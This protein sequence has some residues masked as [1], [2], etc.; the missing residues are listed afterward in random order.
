MR[1]NRRTPSATGA[2]ARLLAAVAF[3]VGVV[4]VSRPALAQTNPAGA[5]NAAGMTVL[6]SPP[7]A[8][9]HVRGSTDLIGTAPLDLGP[10]WSGRY[11]VV[12][13]APGYAAAQGVLVFPERGGTPYAISEPRRF[14]AKLLVHSLYPPGAA[15]LMSHRSARGWAFVAAGVGGLG[16]VI[17]DQ[18]EY[19]DKRDKPDVDLQARAGDFR[20]AR[21][22]WALYTGAVWALSAIDNIAHPR[23]DVLES[24]PNRVTIGTPKITRPGLVVRSVLVPGAGQDYAGRSMRGALW[25]GG[26][27]LSGAAYLTADE[28]HH[29]I[30]TKLARAEALLLTATSTEAADRQA[31]VDHFTDLEKRSHRLV[32]RFALTTLAIYAANVIDAGLTPVGSASGPPKK[33]SLVAPIG[34]ETASLALTY[35]F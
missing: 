30:K 26:T 14:T 9:I 18:V 34:V 16:A 6:A 2:R 4:L 27:F 10:Q 15:A 12:V 20:Y 8:L 13:S 25:L 22:R 32:R 29:R 21:D 19:S 7:D 33:V 28:S 11:A 17:R 24:T 31:D 1:P 23:L 35:R 5:G 3:C